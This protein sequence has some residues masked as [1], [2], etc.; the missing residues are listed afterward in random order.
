[1]PSNFYLW[2]QKKYKYYMHLLPYENDV[3]F[4]PLLF[5]RERSR[6]AI[7]LIS[8]QH[9]DV[10]WRRKSARKGLHVNSTSGAQFAVQPSVKPVVWFARAVVS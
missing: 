1:M 10:I 4:T 9:W 7:R 6:I 2:I 8:Q 5:L 3:A